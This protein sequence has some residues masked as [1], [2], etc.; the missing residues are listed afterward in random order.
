MELGTVCKQKTTFAEELVLSKREIERLSGI[1]DLAN[2]E[3]EELSKDKADYM[4]S[5]FEPNYCL[6]YHPHQVNRKHRH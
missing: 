4:V 3:R 6:F 1:L 2:A 5:T